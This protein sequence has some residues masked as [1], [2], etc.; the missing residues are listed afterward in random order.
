MKEGIGSRL[1]S[2]LGL[3]SGGSTWR[4]AVVEVRKAGSTLARRTLRGRA[5]STPAVVT[6]PRA[7]YIRSPWIR[8][9]RVI[10][11][12]SCHLVVRTGLCAA[13]RRGGDGSQATEGPVWRGHGA[14]GESDSIWPRPFNLWH[15]RER[16]VEWQNGLSGRMYHFESQGP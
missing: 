1:Y 11:R 5:V 6:W 10:A 12:D 7:S 9:G 8:S 2:S 14:V 4:Y 15:L 13:R 3:R 16:Q